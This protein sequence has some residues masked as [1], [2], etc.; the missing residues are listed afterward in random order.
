MSQP[1]QSALHTF[2]KTIIA[3]LSRHTKAIVITIT[4]IIIGAS[5]RWEVRDVDDAQTGKLITH[6]QG[7]AFPWQRCGA[8]GGGQ[9]IKF[10]VHQ[11]LCYGLVS[12]DAKGMTY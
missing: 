9:P 1:N 10:H 4:V 6:Y 2:M 5:F 7:I 3:Y 12:V 8:S 11:W